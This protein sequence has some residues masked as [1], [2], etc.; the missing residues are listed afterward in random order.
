MS[1]VIRFSIIAVIALMIALGFT[2][3]QAFFAAVGEAVIEEFQ[4]GYIVRTVLVTTMRHLTLILTASAIVTFSL[5]L[6]PYELGN[7]GSLV[8]AV[9][10]LL[11]LFVVIAVLGGIWFG[12][13]EP[14]VVQTLREFEYESRVSRT[15][16]DDARSYLVQRDLDKAERL[17]RIHLAVEGETEEGEALLEEI[18]EERRIERHSAR[19]SSYIEPNTAE[20]AHDTEELTVADLLERAKTNLDEGNYYS[21]HYLATKAFALSGEREDIRRI[22]AEALRGIQGDSIVR[23]DMAERELYLQKQRAYQLLISGEQ[24]ESEDPESTIKAYYLFLELEERIPDDGDVQVF[25]AKAREK[26]QNISFFLDEAGLN[27]SDEFSARTDIV[28]RYTDQNGTVNTVVI[29]RIVYAREGTFVYDIEVLQEA[30]HRSVH[31][32]ADYGKYIGDR[33]V[34]RA[35]ERGVPEGGTPDVIDEVVLGPRVIGDSGAK[36]P[37][38]ILLVTSEEKPIDPTDLALLGAGNDR[39]RTL[40]IVELLQMPSKLSALGESSNAA[41]TAFTE[42][43]LRIFGLFIAPILAVAFGWRYRGHY[44]SRPPFLVLLFIPVIPLVLWW[45][46]EIPVFLLHLLVNRLVLS[47]TPG[48]VIAITIGVLFLLL[49]GSVTYLSRQRVDR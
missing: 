15:A 36:A 33:I 17:V 27:E 37:G 23:E 1:A 28:V 44:L 25:L 35:I 8:S 43:I 40:S 4:M 6:G 18:R 26:V 20:R 9:Q 13:L 3:Y 38:H 32:A 29:G 5:A 19:L 22:Q 2:A 10:P 24:S 14:V 16:L 42:R 41:L 34:F 31:F 49:I 7:S 11:Y 47:M 21:A 12:A 45:I 48:S 46:R 30:G 39:Y